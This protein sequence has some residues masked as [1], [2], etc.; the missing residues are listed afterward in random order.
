MTLTSMSVIMTVFVLNL[1]HRG[2]NK[3]QVPR[4]MKEL[5]VNKISPYLCLYESDEVMARYY[6]TEDRFMKNVSLKL[7]LDN[8]QQALQNETQL[9][10][11]IN[12]LRETTVTLADNHINSV[13]QPQAVRTNMYPTVNTLSPQQCYGSGMPQ[14]TSTA[15]NSNDNHKRSKRKSNSSL[16][17]T[18]EEIL[19]SLRRILEK[20]EKEDKDYE[21]IQDWRRVAQVIDRILFIIFFIATLWST[22]GILVI[23]PASRGT[24]DWSITDKNIIIVEL[25]MR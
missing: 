21:M 11:S 5:L 14:S 1:H 19:H 6:R 23:A 16:G 17:K 3:R 12:S 18:N 2:P 13:S 24:W 8:I 4:W 22:I 7:T 15:Q 25:R 10:N 20:H 9:E